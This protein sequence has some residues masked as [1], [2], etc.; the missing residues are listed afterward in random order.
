MM[1]LKIVIEY[2]IK[3]NILSVII[4]IITDWFKVELFVSSEGNEILH[5]L[6]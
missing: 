5:I 4:Q 3:Q 1:H 6:M 2:I